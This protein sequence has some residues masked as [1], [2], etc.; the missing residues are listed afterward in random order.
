MGWVIFLHVVGACI[1]VGG[2]MVLLFGWLPEALQNRDPQRLLLYEKKYERIGIP[3]LFV[4]VV[5]GLWLL[6]QYK[7]WPFGVGS[8]K[9]GL[10]K[11]GL[12]LF[13]LALA[14]HARLA[15]LPALSP[16]KLKVLAW[17]ISLVTICAILM[18]LVGVLWRWGYFS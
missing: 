15:L 9:M 10:L 12:L 8:V 4:Q 2:H 18:A 5:T 17:H 3:A 13:T 11:I 16:G 14:L 1:W 7:I 6:Y